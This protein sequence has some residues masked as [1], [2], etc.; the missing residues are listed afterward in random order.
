[1][2]KRYAYFEELADGKYVPENTLGKHYCTVW[3][4]K[5]VKIVTSYR[6]D[7]KIILKPGDMLG[8]DCGDIWRV[9]VSSEYKDP[10]KRFLAE[11]KISSNL[12]NYVNKLPYELFPETV[13]NSYGRTVSLHGY[14]RYNEEWYAVERKHSREPNNLGDHWITAV[15]VLNG[16]PES[17]VM[18]LLKRLF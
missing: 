11:R 12:V 18:E 13:E 16:T 2:A 3:V 7:K 1:M 4:G 17:K 8:Y 10:V 5:N 15:Y 6:G 14:S 9:P